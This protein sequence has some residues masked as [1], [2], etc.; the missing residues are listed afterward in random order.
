MF[1]PLISFG[2]N[3]SWRPYAE[4]KTPIWILGRKKIVTG[5]LVRG[6]MWIHMLAGWILTTLWVGGLTGLVKT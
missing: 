2:M 4:R 1:V 3:D 6:Y 5:A